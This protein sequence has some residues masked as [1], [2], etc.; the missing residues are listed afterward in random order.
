M[1][2]VA[3]AS[4]LIYLAKVDALYLLYSLYGEIIIPKEVYK[5]AVVRGLEKGF[6]DAAKVEEAVRKGKLTIKEAPASIVENILNV[7]SGL[8]RGEAEVLALAL[9]IGRCHVIV[10]DK[11]AR[12]VARSLGLKPHGTL[13]LIASAARRQIIPVDEALK[14]LD[15]LVQ[16]GFRISAKLYLNARRTLEVLK[17][18]RD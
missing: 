2:A 9:H 13:Y 3:N 5:E 6:E 16:S 8:D 1:K 18:K 17:S 15:D 12:Q 10:D 14:L 11:L 4:P 7:A